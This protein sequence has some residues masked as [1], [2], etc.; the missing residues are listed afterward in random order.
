MKFFNWLYCKEFKEISKR[1]DVKINRLSW[2]N[3]N[4]I[5]YEDDYGLHHPIKELKSNKEFKEGLIDIIGIGVEGEHILLYEKVC[6]NFH[7]G[8]KVKMINKKYGEYVKLK[9]GGRCN[10]RFIDNGLAEI[11]V[12]LV[13]T[14]PLIELK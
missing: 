12:D 7:I 2:G 1:L 4:D 11:I 10:I 5:F 8:E 6:E 9:K 14:M 13:S 3:H